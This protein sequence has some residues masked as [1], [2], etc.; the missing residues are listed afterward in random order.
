MKR[1]CLLLSC[2]FA[3]TAYAQQGTLKGNINTDNFPEVSFVWNEYNPD[4]LNANHFAIK[5]NGAD[6]ALTVENITA[7]NIPLKNKT[8]LFL[9]EYQLVRKNQFDFINALLYS[10]LTAVVQSD[11]TT[12]FNVAVFNRKQNDEPTLVSK[13]PQ[14]TSDESSLKSFVSADIEKIV[15]EKYKYNRDDKRN[16][17]QKTDLLSAIREGLDLIEKEPKN[18]ARAIVVITAGQFVSDIEISPIIEQSLKKKI[19]IYI[20]QYPTANSNNSALS[21][22]SKETYG[23]FILSDGNNAD[24]AQSTRMELFKVF[25]E[26]SRRHYGQD[27]KISFTS[28]LSRNGKL[29]P[30]VLN[31]NGAD[32]NLMPYQTPSFSLFVWAKAN[33]VLFL[34]LLVISLAVITFSVIFGIKFIK[35]KLY[36][37]KE[38]KQEEEHKKARQQAEQEALKR[39]LN[40]TQETLKRQQKATEQ[41]KQQIQE[42]EQIEQLAKLMHTKNLQPRILAVN[43]SEMFNI[44]NVITTIGR[45]DDNDIVF[46]D[47]TVSKYH[48]Q[49]VFNGMGFEICDLQSANGIIVNGQYIENGELKNGDIIQLGETVIKFYI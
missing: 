32:Y 42:Q 26:I 2:V 1:I 38:Q 48:A 34:I 23:Q 36:D 24:N 15:V 20:I 39:K 8:I 41:E 30:L 46:T 27:Y 3:I 37:R 43:S 10:F 31:S 13:L 17:P 29:Y 9:W 5:E 25:N 4:T 21:R 19:P 28:L 12:T 16:I 7:D 14:F 44:T 18:N 47:D 22:L 40:E 49:I 6:L 11:T 35:E 45:N 33:L